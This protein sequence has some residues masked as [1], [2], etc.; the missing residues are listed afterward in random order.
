[1]ARLLLFQESYACAALALEGWPERVGPYCRKVEPY[2]TLV[3]AMRAY[4][5]IRRRAVWRVHLQIP[6]RALGKLT[7][8]ATKL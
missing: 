7:V 4:V 6:Q 1:M 5:R 2:A 8:Y 3:F